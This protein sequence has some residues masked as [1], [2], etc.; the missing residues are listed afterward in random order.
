MLYEYFTEDT[1]T[2]TTQSKQLAINEC[3]E[4]IWDTANSCKINFSFIKGPRFVW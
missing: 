4:W 2:P 3:E 1:M